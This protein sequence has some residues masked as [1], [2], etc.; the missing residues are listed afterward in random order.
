MMQHPLTF[1]VFTAALLLLATCFVRAQDKPA[2]DPD[3]LAPMRK[4]H[5]QFKGDPMYVA[6]FGDSITVSRAFWSPMGWSDPDAFIPD[7]GLPKRP[8]DGKPWKQAI[9]GVNDEDG[10]GS[11]WSADSVLKVIDQALAR[12]T[13]AIAIIMI[14]TNDISGDA[15]KAPRGYAEKVEK[16]IAKCLDAKCVPILN[17]IPPRKGYDKAVAEVNGQLKALA[18]KHA[19][20]LVDY[21]EAIVSRQ[22]GDKWLGTLISDDGVHPTAGKTNDYSAENLKV[23]GYALRTW[24]N[25]LMVR[26]VYFKVM[27]K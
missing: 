13:P 5:A 3:W 22:P 9:K 19:I 26:Q 6:R 21:H 24:M 4:L 11:G 17:T 2:G 25:F 27:A 18:T 10:C 23:S 1:T 14:G 7:D 16:I 8:A 12:R 20:P 15:V